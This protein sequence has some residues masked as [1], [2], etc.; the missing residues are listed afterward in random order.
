MLKSI[1]NNQ[2]LSKSFFNV[3]KFDEDLL[4]AVTTENHMNVADIDLDSEASEDVEFGTDAILNLDN[5]DYIKKATY[6]EIRD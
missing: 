4:N 3:A 5:I 6:K 1:R 2:S